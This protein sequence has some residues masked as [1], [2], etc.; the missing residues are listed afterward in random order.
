MSDAPDEPDDLESI[1]APRSV[2]DSPALRESI[3]VQTERVIRRRRAV[4]RLTRLGALAA[5]LMIGIGLGRE[6]RPEPHHEFPPD[7]VY[8]PQVVVVPVVVPVPVSEPSPSPS[9]EKN[10][11]ASAPQA[12]M[13]AE[14]AE[15]RSESARLYRVAGDGYLLAQDYRNAARCY[16]LF[17]ARAGEPALQPEAQDNWLLTSLKNAAFQE[18]FNVGKT[19]G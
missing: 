13:L 3:R 5:L 17:L 1:L 11:S 19:D 7:L 12:E 18:K 16:R 15:D 2:A 14:Q 10:E 4:Q 9:I 8:R 6:L